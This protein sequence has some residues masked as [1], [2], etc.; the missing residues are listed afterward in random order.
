MKSVLRKVISV[1]FFLTLLSSPAWAQGR[2]GT[3]DVGKIFD[4]YWKKKEA[5][6]AMNDQAEEAKKQFKTMVSDY[7]KAKEEYR[8]LLDAAN[9]QAVS[10]EEREKSKKLAEEK[11]KQLKV[12]EDEM[13]QYNAQETERL[14]EQH[15]RV[16]ANLLKEIRTVLDAKAKAAGYALV[17]DTA[18]ETPGGTPIVLYTNHE[19]DLTKDVLDQLNAGAPPEV[20]KT[21][22]TKD[23]KKD[24]KKKSEKR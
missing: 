24:E 3:V 14:K 8:K 5:Q 2:I 13:R 21:E 15:N 23:E 20:P 4:G 6:V 10:S 18:A 16:R 22:D 19:N 17:V 11:F 12:S 1:L 7:D 9:D